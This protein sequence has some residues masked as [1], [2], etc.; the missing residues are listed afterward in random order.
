MKNIIDILREAGVDVPEE[1]Q[2]SVT[3]TVA[4]NY[5]TVAEFEKVAKKRDEYKESL[6]NVEGQLKGFEGVDV[7]NLKGQISSLTAQLER[8][9]Q[10]RQADSAR[11]K[12]EANVQAFLSGKKFI[13]GITE[14]SIREQI[15]TALGEN[16]G[17]SVEQVFSRITT[18]DNGEQLPNIFAPEAENKPRFTS[19]LGSKSAANAKPI[20][21]ED[22]ISISDPATRQAEIARHPDLFGLNFK[23]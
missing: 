20:T 7:D 21:K 22:I 2:A 11:A 10:E 3:K 17:E 14:T 19:P 12:R 13:N 6:E 8:E 23:K 15:L 9:K 1:R 4:D 18:D 16:T 5:K